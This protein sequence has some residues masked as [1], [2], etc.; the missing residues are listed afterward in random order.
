MCHSKRDKTKLESPPVVDREHYINF[1]A[2]ESLRDVNLAVHVDTDSCNNCTQVSNLRF[3][4]VALKQPD[5]LWVISKGA[6]LC[7]LRC[8]RL[9]SPNRLHC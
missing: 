9:P 2:T 3:L 4:L 7:R 5:E 8:L 1:I 6:L